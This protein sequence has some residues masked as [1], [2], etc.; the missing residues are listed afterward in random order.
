MSQTKG[1][2]NRV[3]IACF[4]NRIIKTHSGIMK[5]NTKQTRGKTK[6]EMLEISKNGTVSV[7]HDGYGF[8]ERGFARPNDNCE[9]FPDCG[10]QRR[11]TAID[12]WAQD[13]EAEMMSLP[14][15]EA[16]D[17]FL[18]RQFIKFL[19]FQVVVDRWL[20]KAGITKEKDGDLKFQGIFDKYFFLS[21]NLQRL[22]DRLGLSPAGRK[23]LKSSGKLN[24]VAA[25]LAEI[26]QG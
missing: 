21:N 17:L 4:E 23:Q 3:F 16:A 5:E 7:K 13:L 20:I 2:Q 19:T 1:S 6:K 25:A 26:K 18:V 11:C 12:N 9:L 22:A 8:L 10:C 15:I 14:H 24:D